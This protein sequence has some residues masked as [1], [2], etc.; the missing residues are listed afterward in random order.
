MKTLSMVILYLLPLF[1]FSQGM[2]IKWEDSDGREFSINTHSAQFQYSMIAGDKLE[3][4][5]RY[6]IGPEGSIKS[7]GKVLI[8]YNGRYDAG[9]EGSVKAVGNIN[10]SYNSRYEIGPEGSIKSV[11]GLNIYYNGKYDSGPEG[12]IKNTTGSVR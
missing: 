3:Y 10:I 1:G 8:Q 6:E 12:S 7:I 4:I 5:S 9:P 11:G 2:K